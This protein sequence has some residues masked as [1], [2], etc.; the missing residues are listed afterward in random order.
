[1]VVSEQRI[2]VS[3]RLKQGCLVLLLLA[4]TIGIPAFAQS[5]KEIAAADIALY[6]GADRDQRLIAAAKKEGSLL[7]YT[8]MLEK[9]IRRIAADFEEKYG[10]KVNIWR[11]GKNKVLQRT[12]TEARGGRFEVDVVHNPSPEMEALHREKLLQ[13][14]ESPY[15]KELV[16][17]AQ[18]AHK[19]WVAARIYVFVQA[20]NTDKV[21]KEELPKTYRD[22]LD[23]KW[24]GRLGI[25][26]KEQEWFFTLIKDMGEEKG[27]KLFRDIVATNGLSVRTG[28]ALLNNL[29][30]SGEVPLALTVYSYLPE[31]AKRKGAP[32]DWFSLEPVIA[33]T[34]AVGVA[35]KSPHPNAA[36]LFYDYM[37]SAAQPTLAAMHHIPTNKKVASPFKDINVQQVKFIDPEKVL[38]EYERWTKLYEDTI[39]GRAPD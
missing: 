16:P 7:L 31:Q 2:G 5:S 9:N 24:K 12:I 37:I 6:S 19:E 35:K 27:L 23:P 34:D 30:I 29:V 20:Y 26:S 17:A 8:S 38:D 25:E 10:I 32:I 36:V 33:Y 14:V 4:F 13:P 3:V 15:Y 1:M 21:K 22:L 39:L 18:P 11:A 28:H